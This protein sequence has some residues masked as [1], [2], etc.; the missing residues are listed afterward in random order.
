MI[1]YLNLLFYC[2]LNFKIEIT[3]NIKKKKFNNEK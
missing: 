1:I 2:N 3:F